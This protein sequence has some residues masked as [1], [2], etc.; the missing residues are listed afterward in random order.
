MAPVAYFLPS[1]MNEA[2]GQENFW[3]K[4]RSLDIYRPVLKKRVNAVYWHNGQIYMPGYREICEA[5]KDQRANVAAAMDPRLLDLLC[6]MQAWVR[7]Y[8]FNDPIQ[9]NS[10]YRTEA[11]NSKIE[12]AARHSMHIRAQAVDCVFPGLPTSYVGQLAH[13]YQAGGVGFYLDK[14]F[15]HVD[16]G[17]QRVWVRK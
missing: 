7:Y 14:D 1:F 13:R 10:G 2:K 16:T 12:G 11:S 9:I 4:P 15:I 6:A 17:R 5:L 3:N 8:G